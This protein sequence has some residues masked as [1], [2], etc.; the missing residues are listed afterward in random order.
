MLCN[1]KFLSLYCSEMKKGQKKS[2]N[3]QKIAITALYIY[4]TE[5]PSLLLYFYISIHLYFIFG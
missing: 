1:I 3:Q 2:C 4:L 5:I